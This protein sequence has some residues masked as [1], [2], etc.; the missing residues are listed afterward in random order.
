MP[1][2]LT[3]EMF[4]ERVKNNHSFEQNYDYSLTVY[5]GSN[6]KVKVICSK[7]GVFEKR[8]CDLMM[9]YGCPKCGVEKREIKPTFSTED[10]VKRAR[11]VHGD[12][13]DYSKSECQH[14]LDVVTIICP[15]HGEFQQ[16]VG[17]HLKGHACPKC[18]DSLKRKIS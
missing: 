17:S 16:S 14:K 5:T 8:A 2:R 12:K 4:I 15:E 1:S 18:G 7:H 11:E 13:Y 10:F 3:Q 6:K 9:G